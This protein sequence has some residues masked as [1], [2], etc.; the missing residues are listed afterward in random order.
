MNRFHTPRTDAPRDSALRPVILLLILAG[1]LYGCGF[2][3]RGQDT[4]VGQLPAK[5]LIKGLASYDPLYRSLAGALSRAGSTVVSET[6]EAD[7]QLSFSDHFYERRVLTLDR[8]AKVIEYELEEAIQF[9]LNDPKGDTRIEDQR[10]RVLRTVFA[11][12]SGVLGYSREIDEV[13]ENMRRDL[14]R[15]ILNRIAAQD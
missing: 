6:T 5:V 13:R 2:Q 3:P 11:P 1:L 9:R 12:P 10:V 4:A 7:V 14:S 8:R 15:R